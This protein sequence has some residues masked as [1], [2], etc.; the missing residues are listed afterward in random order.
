[1]VGNRNVPVEKS[2]LGSLSAD[3]VPEISQYFFRSKKEIVSPSQDA[4]ETRL[5]EF[6]REIQ[7]FTFS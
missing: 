6:R 4:F 2:V 5:Y 1:M 7:V 3:F